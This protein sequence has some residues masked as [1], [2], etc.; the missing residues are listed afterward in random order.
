MTT[1]GAV[2]TPDLPPERL[3][4]V[5]L[6]AER[7]G[8]AELWLWEDCFRESGV[9]SAAA[10]LGWTERLRVGVG[11]LPVPLRNV[12]L[13]AME[14]ATLHRLF[15][16]RPVVGVGHGVQSWMAQVGAR[17]A[18]P[19]TLLR[20]QVDAL[21]ALL[22]GEEVTVEGRYVQLDHV[23]L[24]WPPAEPVPVLAGAE[25]PRTLHLSGAH[26]DGTVLTGGT[27]SSEVRA[28]VERVAAGRAEAGRTDPHPVTVYV[29][30]ATGARAAER[31]AATTRRIFDD[32]ADRW[33]A[34]DDA[35]DVAQQ[36]GRWTQ[37]GADVLVLQPAEG[38]SD[39][40][41]FV[42]FAAEV[43]RQLG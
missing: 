10:V 14:L 31:A 36:L 40:E 3:R 6:A 24:D 33:V 17:P 22:A 15:P 35:A 38:E 27:S 11:V 9:A 16:G 29:V 39:V 2:F 4:P 18:S 8:L 37:A 20:E 12:A 13:T 42:T 7:A 41:A 43:G 1:V 21:R 34:G 5:A 23:R 26:A 19:L 30:T 28:A 32:D 25:G